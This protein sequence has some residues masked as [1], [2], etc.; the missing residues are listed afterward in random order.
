MK[1]KIFKFWYLLKT[2]ITHSD[3]YPKVISFTCDSKGKFKTFFGGIVSIMLRIMIF[4]IA[5]LLIV[6]IINRSNS[7]FSLTTIQKDL[8]VDE[9]KKHYFAMNDIFIGLSLIGPNP[10]ILLDSTYFT[11]EIRQANYVSDKTINSIPRSFKSIPYEFWAID[12]SKYGNFLNSTTKNFKYLW[13]KLSDFFI[14]SNYNSEKY[15]IIEINLI[16]CTQGKWKSQEEINKAFSEHYLELGIVS[17]Y[18][19]YNN[20]KDPIRY[21]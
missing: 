18:F 4:V 16:K 15:E 2:K 11:L 5:V 8:T 17:T 3:L 20:Y 12:F 19:D 13:P 14:R 6:T 7:S 1:Q 21:L 10:D 9:E